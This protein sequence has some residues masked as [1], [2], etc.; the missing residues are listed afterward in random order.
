MCQARRFQL[1]T[2]LATFSPCSDRE[3]EKIVSSGNKRKD[4]ENWERE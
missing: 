2:K 1:G 3:R 4:T